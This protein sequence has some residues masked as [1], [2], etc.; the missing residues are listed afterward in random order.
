MYGWV[1]VSFLGACG[2]SGTWSYSVTEM[3]LRVSLRLLT[4][5][6]RSWKGQERAVSGLL[7]AE[8]C[9]AGLGRLVLNN[10]EL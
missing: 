1:E 2:D 5:E 4:G 8:L 9:P 3:L 6:A 7:P 10:N